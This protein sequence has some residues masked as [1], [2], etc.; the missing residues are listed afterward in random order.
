MCVVRAGATAD[1]AGTLA[2]CGQRRPRAGPPVVVALLHA[3]NKAKVSPHPSVKHFTVFLN[4]SII[5]PRSTVKKEL[6]PG[7]GSATKDLS[8]F[9]PDNC[10]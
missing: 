4:F 1:G 6:D 2:T 5:H 9:N 10:Y 8:N 7:S 3:Q